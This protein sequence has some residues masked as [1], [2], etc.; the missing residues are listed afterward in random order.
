MDTCNIINN[1]ATDT[2]DDYDAVSATTLEFPAGSG[3][4]L[5]RCITVDITDDLL[6][7]CDETFTVSL[8]L[9]NSAD[10]L[11]TD[12]TQTTVTITDSDSK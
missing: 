3:N 9:I 11:N 6:I 8:T 1:T 12:N 5:T 2:E 4:S 7:E 10:N